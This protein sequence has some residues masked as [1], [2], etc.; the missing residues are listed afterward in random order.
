MRFRYGHFFLLLLLFT[1]IACQ[2]DQS[3]SGPETVEVTR[4]VTEIVTAPADS[5][6]VT[7]LV[8]SIIEVTVVPDAAA[9]ATRPL[10]DK[11]LTVCLLR[12]PQS[13]YPYSSTN[14]GPASLSAEAIRHGVY[15]NMV[16]TLSY[17]FQAHGV[18]K[19]P[20]LDDGDAELRVVTAADG[21]LVVNAAGQV[22]TL[23]EGIEIVNANGELLV[24]AGGD[25]TMSQLVVNFSLQP[26]VWSD[27]TL[28]TADDSVF[29]FELAADPLTPI[30]K[31]AINR[32]AAYVALDDT[33][34]QWTGL[35]GWVDPT[36]FAN[37]WAPL[38]RHQLGG[39]TAAEIL[40][41][42]EANRFP[43]SS[44]PFVVAEWLSGEQIVM[45]P[46][47]N[48]Y[49]ASEG[50]PKVDEVVFKFVPNSDQLVTR[51]LSGQCDIATQDGLDITRAPLLLEGEA[52]GVLDAHF[53]FT[54][55]FEHIDF[56]LVTAP[57]FADTRPAWFTDIRV[58]QAMIHCTN[59][60]RMVDEIFYGLSEVA[61]TFVP[62]THPLYPE[63]ITVYDYDPALGR[64]ILEDA[65]VIDRDLD[66][67]REEPRIRNPLKFTLI[68]ATGSVLREQV[69]TIFQE[70]MEACGIEVTLAELPPPE[71]YDAS[72]PLFGRRFDLAAFP[73]ISGLMPPCDLYT[74]AQI[75]NAETNWQGN[76]N[77]GFSSELYDE[78]C[79]AAN[80]ALW[81]SDSFQTNHQAAM[82]IL[83][84]NLP[85]IP[86]FPYVN[87]AASRAGVEGVLLDPTQPSELWN[88]YELD[89]TSP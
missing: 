23:S 8:E 89:V 40:E 87:V 53:A 25:V 36:Y 12:E 84:D 44:G 30:D 77:T 4:V 80:Q 45:T 33:T 41:S 21:D 71:L 82:R 55:V 37:I 63:G 49:R 83:A 9:T 16:T 79:Q 47:P 69:L 28:V 78:A 6:E 76:N 57:G 66:G 67:I 50:L 52:T 34:V 85:I 32:T 17:E 20:S 64:E 54:P 10:A 86:L 68:Y 51:L 46:N 75:P 11:S 88:L 1:L 3:D 39:F 43:L 62:S 72:G 2:E 27:G 24:Y 48:Y 19:L 35:P 56:G 29:S 26:L 70:N 59:R 81:Y 74:T 31:D 14:F 5:V 38:P 15:E 73:W 65:G 22:A 13:L 7:R 61:D 18:T 60:Q 42:D 58:R